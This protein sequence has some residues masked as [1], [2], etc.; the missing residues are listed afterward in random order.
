MKYILPLSGKYYRISSHAYLRYLFYYRHTKLIADILTGANA[1][2]K[3]LFFRYSAMNGGK[4]LDLLK[5]FYNY[6]YLELKVLLLTSSIDTRAATNTIQSRAG[7]SHDAISVSPDEDL[8]KFLD[9]D[10]AC[11]LVDE[12][13]FFSKKQVLQLSDIVDFHNIPVICYGLRSNYL[14][15]AFESTA[16]LMA[17]ADN[18]EELKT[19]CFCGRKATFNMLI[20]DGVAQKTGNPIMVDDDSLKGKNQKYVSVC[21]LHYKLGNY[22]P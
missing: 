16:L 4:T 2:A 3:K 12:V 1:V 13:Q 11:I 17:I 19:I 6:E 8:L 7:I 22:K 9:Q 5:V 18:I 15:E 20:Q 21:R 14:G 10:Y